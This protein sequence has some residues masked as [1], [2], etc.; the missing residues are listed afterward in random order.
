MRC[1]ESVRYIDEY[2]S[3]VV[4]KKRKIHCAMVA[5][6]DESIGIVMKTVKDEVSDHCKHY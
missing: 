2:C 1:I 5:A 3:H 6:M 4:E